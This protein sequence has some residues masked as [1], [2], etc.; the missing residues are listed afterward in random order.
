MRR[1]ATLLPAGA[2]A[3]AAIGHAFWA[4]FPDLGGNPLLD[5]IAYH[6][7]GFHGP[8]RIWYYA[9]PAIT[10]HLAG[11]LGLSVWRVW[12]LPRVGAGGRGKLPPWSA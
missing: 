11:N 5:L 4:P 12:H 8:I 6:D 9:A 2:A 3:L 1:P 7:P 10:V